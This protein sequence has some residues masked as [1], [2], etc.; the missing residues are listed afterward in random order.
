MWLVQSSLLVATA[1]ED[2]AGRASKS[3][4]LEDSPT[5]SASQMMTGQHEAP[6]KH[7]AV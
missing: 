4:W 7:P 3:A 6:A 5:H 2:G 1:G